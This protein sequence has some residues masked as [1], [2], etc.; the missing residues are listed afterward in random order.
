MASWSSAAPCAPRLPSQAHPHCSGG[1]AWSVEDLGGMRLPGRSTRVWLRRPSATC[2]GRGTRHLPASPPHV[3][4]VLPPGTWTGGRG[5]AR[6]GRRRA[7]S[8]PP[9][10]QPGRLSGM[11]INDPRV[12]YGLPTVPLLL[13]VMFLVMKVL[14]TET[15]LLSREPWTAPTIMVVPGHPGEVQMKHP[16]GP[17]GPPRHGLSEPAW[18]RP[19]THR[20]PWITCFCCG[21]LAGRLHLPWRVGAAGNPLQNARPSAMP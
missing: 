3:P 19:P 9:T 20:Q 8:F 12:S 18:R 21:A 16:A 5:F 11:P 2:R 17:G 15:V 7:S 1:S 4:H 6:A 14:E 13:I 10:A